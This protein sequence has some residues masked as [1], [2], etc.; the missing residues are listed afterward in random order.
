MP[1]PG[2]GEVLPSCCVAVGD[3]ACSGGG[4]SVSM[5]G[6]VHPLTGELLPAEQD[7]LNEALLDAERE[8]G[9]IHRAKHPILA[10]LAELR[11]PAVLPPLRRRT[12]TQGRVGRCPRCGEIAA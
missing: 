7:I 8:I 1:L 11:G 10:A 4:G 2:S 12:D 5:D 6:F 3:G 9:R